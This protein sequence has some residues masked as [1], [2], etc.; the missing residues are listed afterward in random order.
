MRKKE[1]NMALQAGTGRQCVPL[2]GPS[3]D[4]PMGQRGFTTGQIP[5]W[6]QIT[7]STDLGVRNGFLASGQTCKHGT[8]KSWGLTV[9]TYIC[10]TAPFLICNKKEVI[11]WLCNIVT[12]ILGNRK[13]NFLRIIESF[14]VFQ[15]YTYFLNPYFNLLRPYQPLKKLCEY[16]FVT[17]VSVLN[18]KKKWYILANPFPLR[19]VHICWTNVYKSFYLTQKT[20]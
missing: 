14:V 7:S 20:K 17:S 6:R 9:D 13:K 16:T 15:I 3:G 12:V 8:C 10:I 5:A 1:E 19:F 11:Y 2:F 18:V 4:T